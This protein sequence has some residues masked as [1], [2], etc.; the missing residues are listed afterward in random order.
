MTMLLDRE[1]FN[2]GD[3]FLFTMTNLERTELFISKGLK[4]MTAFN[5]LARTMRAKGNSAKMFFN[6]LGLEYPKNINILGMY[7]ID[8]RF[9]RVCIKF[10]LSHKI[11]VIKEILFDYVITYTPSNRKNER[12]NSGFSDRGVELCEIKNKLNLYSPFTYNFG[13]N[14]DINLMQNIIAIE[15]YYNRYQKHFEKMAN[16]INN[17][18]LNSYFDFWNTKKIMWH[19]NNDVAS[20]P[21]EYLDFVDYGIDYN[22]FVGIESF[23]YANDKQNNQIIQD[24]LELM[25]SGNV[26]EGIKIIN[27][28]LEEFKNN[29]IFGERQKLEELKANIEEGKKKIAEYTT[30]LAKEYGF[31]ETFLIHGWNLNQMPDNLMDSVRENAMRLRE[32][33]GL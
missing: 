29:Y 2:S 22:T 18:E 3:K 16:A 33:N 5:D 32:K 21:S 7:D 20:F 23:I 28:S 27:D 12:S 8:T 4:G 11:N 10:K 9:S 31:H 30:K 26:D 6:E 15:E 24:A 14:N 13:F 25:H 17:D 19:F 1:Y